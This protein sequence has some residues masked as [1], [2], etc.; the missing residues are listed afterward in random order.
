MGMGSPTSTF[1]KPPLAGGEERQTDQVIYALSHD[2]QAPLLNLNGFLRRLRQ[3]CNALRGQAESWP[4]SAEQRG[5]WQQNLDDKILRSLEILDQNTRRMQQRVQ[6]LLELSRA[7]GGP[8][9]RGHVNPPELVAAVATEFREAAQ[10]RG[11]SLEIEPLPE[12][13][14]AD[15]QRLREVLRRLLGNAL[16][17]LS[18]DRPGRIT[19]GG[20]EEAGQGALWVR[21]NG[22]G[23][24]AD[25]QDRLFLPF[26]RAREI[27]T[28]GEGIGL[29][30]VRKLMRQQGGRVW[31]ESTH[32]QGSRFGVAWP[33]SPDQVN[34]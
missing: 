1:D 2:L 10:A 15:S 23:I 16:K 3:G 18:P 28:E 5:V 24:R 27:E 32:G 12:R 19:I 31:V 6:A 26:G 34:A 4:L 7:G 17:F 14:H 29:A 9:E 8:L 25:D 21:D 33:T 20:N 13:W 22:I 30:I 11:A